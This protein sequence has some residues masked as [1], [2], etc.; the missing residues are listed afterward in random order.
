MHDEAYMGWGF[1]CTPDGLQP[2][3]VICDVTLSNHSIK[4]SLL[5]RHFN[6][7]HSSMKGKLKDFF[8]VLKDKFYQHSRQ[9]L[10]QMLI[11]HQNVFRHP[12]LFLCVRSVKHRTPLFKSLWYS[13]Q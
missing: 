5:Q 4:P 7:Y 2:L 8:S 9:H 12:T 6:S 11:F 13:L 10:R 1:S 3:C